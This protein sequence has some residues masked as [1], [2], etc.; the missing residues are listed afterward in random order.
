MAAGEC[1][2]GIESDLKADVRVQVLRL[3]SLNVLDYGMLQLWGFPM[4]VT[5]VAT[6]GGII[7][8]V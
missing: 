8:V 3:L 2:T 5:F 7:P 1:T 6:L 4:Y